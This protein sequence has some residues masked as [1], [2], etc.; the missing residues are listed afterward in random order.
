M[1]K[2][3]TNWLAILIL[4]TSVGLQAEQ[5]KYTL[6]TAIDF[7][8]GL[9]G[10]ANASSTLASQASQ[11]LGSFSYEAS[12][13]IEMRSIGEHSTLNVLYA[14]GFTRTHSDLSFNSTSHVAS[15]NFSG[16]LGPKW[17][18]SFSDFFSM[19]SDFNTFNTTRGG[20]SA[21][22]GSRFLI[23][24]TAD[25]LSSRMNNAQVQTD[26]SLNEKSTLSIGG[27]HL[28]QNYPNTLLS[29]GSYSD[30]QRT[31]G[32][33]TYARRTSEHT[34]WTLGYT[35]SY[36]SFSQFE[37]ARVQVV[38]VGHSR[39]IRPGLTLRLTAGPSYVTAPG[40]GKSYAAYNASVTL[41]QSIKK[42][43]FSLYYAQDS[44]DASGLNAVSGTRRAGFGMDRLVGN[45]KSL[46]VDLSAFD[47]QGKIGNPYRT[48]GV[49]AG[50]NM[51]VRLTRVL[52]IHWGGQYQRYNQPS[53]VSFEQKRLFVSL[54]V[55]APELWKFSR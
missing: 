50:A 38:N 51:G 4:T 42:N 16:S 45:G 41:H 24:P 31:S 3:K 52:S 13:S 54:R 26:Y 43:T 5:R 30:Q 44:G 36:L 19:T 15:T 37:S 1:L 34:T 29:Q 8:G 6:G 49:S 2:C 35:G 27:S 22:E 17:K 53:L 14:F 46:F 7:V 39:Q 25:R 9:G 23:Y 28:L 55:A 11:Q 10:P 48:R 32:T 40:L 21:P 12:P 33:I 47:T 18:F 20:L